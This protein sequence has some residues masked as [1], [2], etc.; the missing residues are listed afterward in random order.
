M[1]NGGSIE[2]WRLDW[3]ME[4]QLR[5]GGSIGKWRLDWKMEAQL[6]NGGS[7]GKSSLVCRRVTK[8]GIVVVLDREFLVWL[9]RNL[10]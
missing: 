3:K 6:K 8:Q 1:K 7:I 10:E 4:A 5:N 9:T 2:K